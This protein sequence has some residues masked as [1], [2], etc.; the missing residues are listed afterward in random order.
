M[1]TDISAA[2]QSWPGSLSGKD[3]CVDRVQVES[4][5]GVPMR[6]RRGKGPSGEIQ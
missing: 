3:N 1:I 2:A 4:G 6:P 5:E